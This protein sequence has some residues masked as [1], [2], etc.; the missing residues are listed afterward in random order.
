MSLA[1]AFLSFIS[2]NLVYNVL[3]QHEGV[4]GQRLVCVLLTS[5]L[6]QRLLTSGSA[7]NVEGP[8]ESCLVPKFISFGFIILFPTG[9]DFLLHDTEKIL[10]H[11]SVEQESKKSKLRLVSG[12]TH[13]Q[14]S[15]ILA[16]GPLFYLHVT[17][18][19][20]CRLVWNADSHINSLHPQR[21]YLSCDVKPKWN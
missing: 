5:I 18:L 17:E 1:N 7:V 20:D 12:G 4:A 14:S 19:W 2:W 3:S 8:W 10:Y 15:V 16:Y 13:P 11:R 21:L 6:Y 9:R